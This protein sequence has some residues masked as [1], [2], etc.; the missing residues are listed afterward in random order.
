MLILLIPENVIARGMKS[1]ILG[2]SVLWHQ[3]LLHSLNIGAKMVLRSLIPKF[4]NVQIPYSWSSVSKIYSHLD[5]RHRNKKNRKNFLFLF[6]R[7]KSMHKWSH[8]IQIYVFSRSNCIL[9]AVTTMFPQ[10]LFV[11]MTIISLLGAERILM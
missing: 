9:K 4:W 1:Q 2:N 3:N 6:N 8:Q 11:S 5:H 7:R 10:M